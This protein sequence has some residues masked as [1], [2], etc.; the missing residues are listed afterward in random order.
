MIVTN[1][2]RGRQLAVNFTKKA[3][4]KM[5]RPGKG[6]GAASEDFDPRDSRTDV[7]HVYSG[8][9][10][11]FDDFGGMTSAVIRRTNSFLTLGNAKSATMGLMQ[12]L[13]TPNLAC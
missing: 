11:I 12:G 13:V 9:W 2:I 4:S 8:L 3:L 10:S 6:H 5:T 1:R 7:V